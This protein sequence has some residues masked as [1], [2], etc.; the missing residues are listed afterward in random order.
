MVAWDNWRAVGCGFGWWVF[1]VVFGQPKAGRKKVVFLYWWE[2]VGRKS[3]R[4]VLR[5]L[6]V[7]YV[8]R[9]TPYVLH[10][11]TCD[12]RFAFCVCGEERGT[13]NFITEGR[14]S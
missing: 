1:W 4:G 5:V 2:V 13:P 12:L 11:A 10:L 14:R 7:S 8:L 3:M 9:L 6:R